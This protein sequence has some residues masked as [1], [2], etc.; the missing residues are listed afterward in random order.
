M[1]TVSLRFLGGNG[2]VTGS[3]LLVEHGTSRVLVDC[4]LF[5]GGRELRARNREPFA[6]A[7]ES[8]DAVV[9]THAHLDHVGHVP[10]LVGQG[11]RGRVHATVDT[12]SLAA[13]VLPDSGRL[14]EEEAA[15]AARHGYSRH[16]PPLPL[17]T[18][19]DAEFAMARFTGHDFGGA[20]EVA[21]G[22]TA[23]FR[24]S[25]HILGSATVELQVGPDMTIVCSGDLG[26]GV[27]P[28]LVPPTP[29]PGCDIAIIESTYGDRRHESAGESVERL[30]GVIVET[31]RLGGRVVIPAFAVDRTEVVLDALDQLRADDQ[32]PDLPVFVDSPMALG[33]LGVYR[34]AID[35]GAADIE[36]GLDRSADLFTH[37]DLRA[38]RSVEE[39][40]RI[41]ASPYP[42]VI[43]S[44][45]GMASGGRVVH[46]LAH[47]AADARSAIVLCGFQAAGTRGRAL[48]DGAR[49]L[50]LLGRYVAIRARVVDLPGFSQHA[51]AD[52][53]VRWIDAAPEGP[54]TVFVVHGEQHA[55]D[56]L[57]ARIRDELGV[58]AVVP[59][60]GERVLAVPGRDRS[61]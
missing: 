56:A 15:H 16:D 2:T 33:A 42:C 25:G 31:A 13:I 14:Q 51:D 29:P 1:A 47:V 21:D 44:A 40:K 5:Q 3:K 53:L 57:A 36:V 19:A 22:I 26:R 18:E 20:V 10:L 34:D 30:A 32:I 58:L 8:V 41:D 4:G 7:P 9:V 17:Y 50:K 43:V 55:S 12:V 11:F 28:L 27:H 49:Q 59:E 23:T 37:L 39:S 6:V 46:H 35:R 24:P 48:L 61:A 52:G 38:A 45:S 54:S 60:H